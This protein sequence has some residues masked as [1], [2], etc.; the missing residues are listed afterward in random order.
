MGRWEPDARGRLA[1]AAMELFRE[2]GFDGTTVA[3]IAERAGLTERT[4]FRYFTDKREVLFWG[5]H[6]LE[7]LMVGGVAA[8]PD[9]AAPIEVVMAAL[10]ATSPMFEERR[11]FARAR[12]ALIMVHPELKERELNKLAALASAVG[13]ALRKRGSPATA[14]TLAAE[15][16][17]SIF[18][19]AFERWL[20]DPKKRSLVHHIRASRRALRAILA[21]GA[22]HPK[23]APG[24]G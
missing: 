4:F 12:Q 15:M 8:A 17:V 7:E 24:H 6:Q 3:D 11:E 18:K 10:E 13:E 5:A 2:R 21:G 20:E 14:S 1:E 22:A 23:R 16:G 19:M 9:A